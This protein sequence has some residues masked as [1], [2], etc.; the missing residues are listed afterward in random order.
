MP[1][2]TGVEKL[3]MRQ[4]T[5]PAHYLANV[6]DLCSAQAG[7]TKHYV[8]TG[9]VDHKTKCTII[10][11]NKSSLPGIYSNFKRLGLPEPEV[12]NGKIEDCPFVG[13]Y[14]LVNL[15]TCSTPSEPILNW[16]GQLSILPGGELNLWVTAFR[17][18]GLWR[19]TLIDGFVYNPQ[20]IVVLNEIR[21]KVSFSDFLCMTTEQKCVVAALAATLSFYDFD[22]VLPK[23]LNRPPGQ[24]RDNRTTMYVYRLVNMKR[25]NKPVRPS[26]TQ[27]LAATRP[28]KYFPSHRVNSNGHAQNPKGM[29]SQ[30]I[31]DAIATGK[32]SEAT[33]TINKILSD[34][35]FL[36][37]SKKMVKAGFK[38]QITKMEKNPTVVKAA[39]AYI[40]SF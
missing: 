31:L 25:R 12:F 39:H 21:D 1:D 26:L 7:S 10:E 34:A 6:L 36:H 27:I 22:F 9:V 28:T 15:D 37:H 3:Q 5:T 17:N 19:Q 35:D 4:A 24:Y 30:Q 40:D 20:G 38:A 33:R 16:I 29:V 23:V 32:R 14:N 13:P 2:Y 8:K 11:H 18:S